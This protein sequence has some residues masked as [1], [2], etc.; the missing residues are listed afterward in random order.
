ME[1]NRWDRLA[2]TTGVAAV[3]LWIIGAVLLFK[4]DPGSGAAPGEVAAHF[5]DNDGQLLLGAF[6]FMLGVA[7]FLWFVGTLRAHIAA[8]EGGVTRTAGILFAGG[9]ATASMLFGLVAPTAA[10]A[11]QAQNDDRPPSPSA[12][13]A[14]WNLGDGFFLAAEVAA[15]VLVAATAVAVLR[16]G[17]FPR[18]VA[19]VSLVLAIWLLIAPIGWL[20][21][22]FGVPAWTLL[23]SLLLWSGSGTLP[24]RRR[25]P[26][27]PESAVP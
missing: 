12:A 6:L 4:D 15:I 10:G 5:A 21:L 16:T 7:F 18:W 26:V 2:P 11:L 13:D 27:T 23:V 9:V 3:V 8:A 19:W 24:S 22:L 14:L 20:A 25:A 17:V 1:S